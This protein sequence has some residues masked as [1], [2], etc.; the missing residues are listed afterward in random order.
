MVWTR[1]KKKWVRLWM[2]LAGVSPF[3]RMAIY[4]ASLCAPPHKDAQSLAMMSPFGYIAPSATLHHSE[5]KLGAHI[6]I[7]DRVLLFQAYNGGAITLGDR[8]AILRDTILETGDGGR[9]T[10]GDEAYIHP[11]CQINAYVT[12]I[13]IGARVLIAANT[14]FYTHNHGTKPGEPII[15]QPLASKGPIVVGDD[16]WIGSGVVVLGGVRIGPGAVVGA[17]SVVTRD[18]PAQS[19]AIGVPAKVVGTRGS[20]S[21]AHDNPP[22]GKDQAGGRPDQKTQ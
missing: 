21:E 3:G 17:G 18:I 6:F 9:I 11:R 4:L 12:A 15:S 20:P 2:H 22:A 14:A 10:V 8:V 5:L 19:I 13:E 7:S 1:A 16:A